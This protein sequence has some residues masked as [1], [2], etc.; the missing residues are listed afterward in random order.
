[1]NFLSISFVVF[2]AVCILLN[3]SCN[4]RMRPY[5]LFLC[6]MFFYSYTN[7]KFLPLILIISVITY[8]FGM[9][10][11]KRKSRSLYALG[12]FLILASLLYYKY[13]NFLIETLNRVLPYLQ[14]GTQVKSLNLIVPLGISFLTFQAVSYVS[15]VYYGKMEYEKN[16]IKVCLFVCFFP[17]ITSGPIQKAR[18]FMPQINQKAVF[19]E[20]RVKYGLYL[21]AFGGLQKFYLS[22]KLY[23]IIDT[24]Q[25]NIREY[26]GFH[27]VFFAVCYSLYIYT[28]FNSYSD[29]AIGIG[30]ILGFQF[31][32]NFRRPYLSKSIKEFWQRWHMSLNSWFVDYIYI[33]LGG[34]RKGKIRYYRNIMTVF[35]LS[36]L[37]HGASWHYIAWGGLN[38]CYQI[39]GNVTKNFRKRLYEKLR[40]SEDMYFV[41]AL[42]TVIA[43]ALIA[44]SWIFFA[45]PSV[46][47]SF[48]IIQS[49][50][51]P[52]ISTLFDGKILALL[53]DTKQIL[54][55]LLEILVFVMIQILREK[56]NVMEMLEKE[57]SM[58]KMCLYVAVAV[59][60]IFGWFG[61]FGSYGNGGFLY[62]NF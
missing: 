32:E 16:F 48:Q 39:V 23:V 52:Q 45:I 28:N 17:T 8:G 38:G 10:L 42:K 60:F 18:D 6:S 9:L 4:Q 55:L 30:E 58:I 41:K 20:K 43:F 5:I 27:Y 25:N 59:C 49:M 47:L 31:H 51:F 61:T 44:I 3:Y 53:G 33:P 40:I 62:A 15:D 2:F 22:D 7:V 36:G 19:D 11:G 37:W 34:S 46:T 29:I 56:K 24:M 57:N 14:M 21:I 1:M 35:L 12:V 13:S 26:S 50:L 54:F